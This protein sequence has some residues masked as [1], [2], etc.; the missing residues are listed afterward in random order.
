M[1]KRAPELADLVP[2][3]AEIRARVPE[4]FGIWLFGSLVRGRARSDSDI[5]LAIAAPAALDP[6]RVFD[7]GLDLGSLAGRDVDLVDLRRGSVL[8]RHV[9]MTEGKLLHAASPEACSTFAADTAALWC[10]LQD[11]QR[12][13]RL[14]P[15]DRAS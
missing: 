15:R 4:A 10:A 8:L 1:S 9:V 14:Y 12:V 6:V 11:E 2:L 5:D 13:M 3:V 7:L